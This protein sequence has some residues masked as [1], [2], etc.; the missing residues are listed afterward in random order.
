VGFVQTQVAPSSIARVIAQL[1]A[2]LFLNQISI[3]ATKQ[4]YSFAKG[5][6]FPYTSNV[7]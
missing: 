5:V 4:Q 3:D 6:I 1:F 7:V 2:G